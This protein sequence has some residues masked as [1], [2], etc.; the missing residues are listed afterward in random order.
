M[1]GSNR[2]TLRTMKLD[3]LTADLIANGPV[4]LD[5]MLKDSVYY[6]ASNED[7]TPI[8]LCNTTWRRLG[9]DSY[10]YCDFLLSVEDFLAQAHTMH[11]YHVLGHRLLDLSEYV[12]EGWKLE[13]VP[14]S[15]DGRRGGYHD[16][17]L[18]GE[19]PEH[20]ACWVVFE[21]DAVKTEIHGP[22][23]LSVLY[24]CGEG[25]ATFQQLYCSRRIAPKMICFIQCWG[26]A[27]N[28]TDFSACGAPFHLTLRKYR[29]CV[30][31]WL[32]FGYHNE[33]AGA[34]RLRS[35][36]SLGLRQVGYRSRR[37]VRETEACMR[38]RNSGYTEAVKY[39]HGER[40][41]LA[42]S[43]FPLMEYAVYDIT[44]AMSDLG[45]LLDSIILPAPSR[46]AGYG[47]S[48]AAR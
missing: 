29:E 1:F 20:K 27:G 12:P 7:G 21:R 19:G 14:K 39:S 6:P 34:V 31:E 4:P 44:G 42:L 26:F 28:W 17:F 40:S 30:P 18:G 43:I 25:L 3:H 8:K 10:V 32:C 46:H 33:V 9:V 35:L 22:E 45:A 36:D 41:Y 37:V 16:T 5:D 24:V 11:G 47:I 2:K 13:C 15:V 48:L 38:V 23:R